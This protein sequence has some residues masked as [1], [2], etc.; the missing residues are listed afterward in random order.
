MF[1]A[2]DIPCSPVFCT[3]PF[4]CSSSS[5]CPGPLSAPRYRL[6]RREAQHGGQ[7]RGETSQVQPCPLYDCPKW[8]LPGNFIYYSFCLGV[9]ESP[10]SVPSFYFMYNIW[11]D[12]GIQT[13]VAAFAARCATNELH[14]SLFFALPV[15]AYG[16]HTVSPAAACQGSLC[17]RCG[18]SNRD[19]CRFEPG[20]L[21]I[22]TRTAV[23]SNRDFYRFEPGLLPIRTETAASAAC[24]A[25]NLVT[26]FFFIIVIP[27]N[28]WVCHQ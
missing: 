6:V 27:H 4:L 17:Y 28:I 1:H 9:K 3:R 25:N 7:C 14:T 18:D 11:Q 23:D 16:L 13:R 20:P 19:R 21:A 22:R 26:W 2:P 15:D 12:A 8:T 5:P 24:C 10:L